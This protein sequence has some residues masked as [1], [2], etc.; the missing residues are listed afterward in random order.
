MAHL[1]GLFSGLI[2]GLPLGTSLGSSRVK[3]A[4]FQTITLIITA[5]LLVA[6]VVETARTKGT[7]LSPV[8]RA[9]ES[10]NFRAAIKILEPAAAATPDNMPVLLTLAEAYTGNHEP[11]KA[12]AVLERVMKLEPDSPVA[13]ALLGNAYA[14]SQDRDK[15]IAAYEQALKLD[16]SMQ[17]VQNAL[18]DLRA[19]SPPKK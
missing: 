17:E 16:P 1:G 12:I 13:Y 5:G 19:N 3:T 11:G 6:G 9:L 8:D 18:Q 7:I 14:E 15:A 4:L 2:I 10:G